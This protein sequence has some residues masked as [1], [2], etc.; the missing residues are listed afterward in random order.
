MP[1]NG[2]SKRINAG[3]STRDRAISNRRRSPPDSVYAPL[4]SHG[5]QFHLRQQF[6]EPVA[7]LLR[8]ERQGFQ[9]RQQ[10]LL[11]RQL[12]ENRRLLGQIADPAA[13]PEVHG[14]VGNVVSVQENAPG[15]RLGQ[16]YQ[17]VERRCLPC[18]VGT[19]EPDYFALANLQI[20]IIY[21]LTPSVR[22]AELDGLQL[23]HSTSFLDPVKR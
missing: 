13:G 19:Q 22:F 14:E 5:F 7:L 16:A 23:E 4:V 9:H 1:E 11:D 20:E 3:S 12:A 21:N 17:D 8:R 18:T 10:I 6:L 2:S 15:V